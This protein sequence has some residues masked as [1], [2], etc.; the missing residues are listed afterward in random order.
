MVERT[1]ANASGAAVAGHRFPG[2]SRRYVL[3][4]AASF[5]AIRLPSSRPMGAL[6]TFSSSTTER[7]HVGLAAC[8]F[9]S[10]GTRA[11]DRLVL[12]CPFDSGVASRHAGVDQFSRKSRF[13]YCVQIQPAGS[14]E[15]RSGQTTGPATPVDPTMRPPTA[16][17]PRAGHR[18]TA[19]AGRRPTAAVDGTPT[20]SRRTTL[21]GRH[22]RMDPL[23]G[24]PGRAP[25]DRRRQ[26]CAIDRHHR[27]RVVGPRA[28]ALVVAPSP[29]PLAVRRIRLPERVVRQG[30]HQIVATT[31]EIPRAI[32][33]RPA[34]PTQYAKH[35]LSTCPQWTR[36]IEL[37]ETRHTSPTSAKPLPNNHKAVQR[38]PSRITAKRVD[39]GAF[40]RISGRWRTQSPR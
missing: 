20:T 22:P 29:T 6:L 17:P 28:T 38:S 40:V 31:P 24:H 18:P 35:P 39:V 19:R 8:A 9:R 16:A 33:N 3:P 14:L 34:V 1:F 21:P 26:M 11:N 13:A 36:G 2:G 32:R 30:R 10:L 4:H 5:A 23:K 7:N 27:R 37:Q 25:P 12:N 15:H